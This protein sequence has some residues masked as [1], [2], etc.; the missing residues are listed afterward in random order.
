MQKRMSEL[1]GVSWLEY[2]V[3]KLAA[4]DAQ[5]SSLWPDF[6]DIVANGLAVVSSVP[7]CARICFFCH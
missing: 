3:Y 7:N 2:T 4:T 6:L 5:S 1:M